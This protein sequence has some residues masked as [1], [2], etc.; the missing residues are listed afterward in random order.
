MYTAATL[1]AAVSAT[2][3]TYTS[4]SQIPE[5]FTWSESLNKFIVG[6]ASRGDISTVDKNGVFATI[7]PNIVPNLATLGV[8]TDASGNI[9]VCISD[10]SKFSG[11]G[12][13]AG[14]ISY[15]AKY[16]SGY[17]Q[18]YLAKLPNTTST[19]NFC[20]D[21]KILA[22]GTVLATDSAANTVFSVSTAGVVT[23]FKKL[24]GII[25]ANN[26]RKFY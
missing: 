19:A 15:V 7:I 6:S 1:L 21:L 13:D 4:P 2:G 14:A 24:V 16:T 18:T 22:N 5:G 11:A 8:K 25:A 12:I 23:S 20:N 26:R 3:I 17:V 10:L 9:Y